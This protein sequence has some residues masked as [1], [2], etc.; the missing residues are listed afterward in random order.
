MNKDVLLYKDGAKIGRKSMFRKDYP[1]LMC[2]V[3]EH[4]FILRTENQTLQNYLYFWLDQG[5]MTQKIINLN[6]NSAQ[7]GINQP[8]VN[9]LPIILPDDNL[10]KLFNKFT[11]LT[12]DQIFCLAKKKLF[13]QKTRDLLVPKLIS[14]EID[15]S[16][17][18]IEINKPMEVVA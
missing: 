14:G 10:I 13:L 7:P 8:G 5:F 11:D 15:V 3:N 12:L 4:V 6:S 9:S 2:C 18:D 16:E 1:H 17:M